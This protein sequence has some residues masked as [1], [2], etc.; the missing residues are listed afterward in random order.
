MNMRQSRVPLH[1]VQDEFQRY[2]LRG[3]AAIEGR[4]VGTSRV[5]VATRL[6]IYGGGYGARLIE[7]LQT[8]FPMLARLLGESDF[9]TMAAEYIR[10]HDS[11]FSSIRYYGN[12]L[13][14]FLEQAAAY[15]SV[16]VL[17]EMARWEWAM[18]EAFDSADAAA[19]EPSAMAQVAPEQWA[20]LRFEWHPSVRHLALAWNVPQVWKALASQDAQSDTEYDRP[21]VKLADDD[22]QWLLWRSK[23]EIFFRS[24]ARAEAAALD[25]ALDGGTFGDVCDVLCGFT[26]EDAAPAQAAGFLREWLQAGLITSIATV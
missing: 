8:N 22:G 20:G 12:E 26:D 25:R 17:A 10:A 15:A 3:D 19:V 5:P 2:L 13:A 23:L 9:E 7:A 14:Q 24:L 21:E 16:P 11:T 18:T 4:V 6:A 1:Q